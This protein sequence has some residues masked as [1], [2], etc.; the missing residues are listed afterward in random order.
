MLFATTSRPRYSGFQLKNFIVLKSSLEIL[1][2]LH[3]ALSDVRDSVEGESSLLGQMI[4]A[5]SADGL[6]EVQ[7]ELLKV[8]DD[9]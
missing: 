5:L 2:E 9:R 8:I 1:P 3:R 7:K 4:D 6:K